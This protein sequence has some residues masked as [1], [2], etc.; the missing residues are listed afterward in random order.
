MEITQE[1]KKQIHQKLKMILIFG[2]IDLISGITFIP[3]QIVGFTLLAA[4]N[5]VTGS[6]IWLISVIIVLLSL[7]LN[8]TLSVII[9]A[10]DFKN[11]EVNDNRILWGLL[12]LF[13]LGGIGIIVF[14]TINIKKYNDD[15]NNETIID[16]QNNNNSEIRTKSEIEK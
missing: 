2:V 15:E 16:N 3:L 12:S 8:I 6:I 1:E 7:I 9:L 13:L 4:F 14:S 5:E 11:K 10:T